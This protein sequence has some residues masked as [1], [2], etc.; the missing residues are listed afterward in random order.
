MG[1]ITP[2]ILHGIPADTLTRAYK[3]CSRN[4]RCFWIYLIHNPKDVV[5]LSFFELI[6]EVIGIAQERDAK[7]EKDITG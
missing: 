3:V 5:V 6:S 4:L 1:S 2:D 7:R